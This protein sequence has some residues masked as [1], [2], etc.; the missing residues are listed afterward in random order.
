LPRGPF[1]IVPLGVLDTGTAILLLI[2]VLIVSVPG[3]ARRVP[4]R[5]TRSGE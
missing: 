2:V 5:R 3:S 1:L 4:G